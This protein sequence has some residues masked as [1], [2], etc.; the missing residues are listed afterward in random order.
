MAD[1]AFLEKTFPSL[2]EDV[3]PVEKYSKLPLLTIPTSVPVHTYSTA[4]EIDGVMRSLISRIE[5]QSNGGVNPLVIGFDTEYNYQR[6]D[7]G[8]VERGNIA[9]VQIALE[10]EIYV[11]RVHYFSVI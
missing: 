5:I 3:E 6:S 8:S 10:A 1:K 9:V 2:R 4:R 11:L 7:H